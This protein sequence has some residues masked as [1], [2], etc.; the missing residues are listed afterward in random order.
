MNAV[1]TQR[2]ILSNLSFEKTRLLVKGRTVTESPKNTITHSWG[3]RVA[4][5]LF[6]CQNIVREADFNLVYWERMGKVMN[7]LLEMFPIWV[8]KLFSHVN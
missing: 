4:Q 3:A 6:H 1:A 7:S 5:K 2:F 8:T